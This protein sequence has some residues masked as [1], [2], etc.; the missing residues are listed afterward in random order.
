MGFLPLVGLS[1]SRGIDDGPIIAMRQGECS[2]LAYTGLHR[3][4]TLPLQ[5]TAGYA[6]LRV[7]GVALW[8]M[9]IQLLI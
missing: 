3:P 5:N 9:S 6:I 7:I 4:A 8:H 1:V 2:V